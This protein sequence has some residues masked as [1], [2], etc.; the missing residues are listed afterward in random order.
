L[1]A[2]LARNGLAWALIRL[3]HLVG[4]F[5]AAVVY[6]PL[7]IVPASAVITSFGDFLI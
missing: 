6:F 2:Y 1:A 5:Y 3:V 4:S 7:L